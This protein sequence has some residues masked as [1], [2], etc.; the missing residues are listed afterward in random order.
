MATTDTITAAGSA[1]RVAAKVLRDKARPGALSAKPGAVPP[2]AE[3]ITPDWLTA[4]LCHDVPGAEVVEVRVTGGDDGTSSR[5]R[6]SIVYNEAGV[7]AG[8]PETVFTKSTATFASRMLL[9]LTEIVEGETLFYTRARPGLRLRSPRAYYAGYDPMSY[10]SLVVLDDL[11]AMGWTFPD[12][13]LNPVTRHDA[14]DMVREL[15]TYHA[16]FWE[17][18]RLSADLGKLRGTYEWQ[19]NLNRRVGFARRTRVG[20][21]RAMDVLPPELRARGAEVF[22]GFMR[23]LELHRRGPRTLLHQD[24]HLGNWLR[25]ADGGMGLYDWQCVAQG[26]WALDYSYALA[27]GL[28]PEDRRAW[29]EELLE[30]YLEQLK[31]SGVAEPPT[32][33]E[34]WLAYRQQP[35]HGLV[36]GLFTLGGSRI[37]PEL[38]PRDYTLFAIERIARFVADAGTLDAID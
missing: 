6:L 5:R 22:P 37:E 13:M 30:L 8:L 27:C 33:D 17:S 35:L 11:S 26:H 12:P 1:V 36:F 18:P 15:A 14:E 16:A 10:R 19:D 3:S 21:R 23:S 2:S 20:F 34:A 32:F 24:V 25:D 4:V 31:A 38:Q 7:A 29:E 9:G 28:A